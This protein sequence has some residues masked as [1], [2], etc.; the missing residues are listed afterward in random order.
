MRKTVQLAIVLLLLAGMSLA[1]DIAYLRNGFTIRHERREVL[2]TNTRLYLGTGGYVDLPST[3]VL[4]YEHDDTLVTTSATVA[5]P[6][7][8][9]TVTDQVLEASKVSGIDPDFLNSVIRHESGFDPRAVSPKGARG[10]M[11]LMPATAAQLGVQ[12]SFDPAQN[13]QGGTTYL[14][15]LLDRYNGDAQKALAAYNAGPHRVEQY[16]GVPPYTETRAYVSNII[17]DYNRKKLAARQSA[18][19]KPR[20]KAKPATAQSIRSI[21]ATVPAPGN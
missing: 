6:A 19:Q 3:E 13:I 21:P 18:Q 1:A 16:K 17:R 15:Q 7:A 12:D 9:K 2:G 11:Q 5:N 10:L 20:Q 4:A 14:K 8:A